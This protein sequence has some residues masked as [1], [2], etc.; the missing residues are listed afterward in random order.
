MPRHSSG[1]RIDDRACRSDVALELNGAGVED[2]VCEH[3][4]GPRG[5]RDGGAEA[6][7]HAAG[8]DGL[9]LAA[10]LLQLELGVGGEGFVGVQETRLSMGATGWAQN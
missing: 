7:D 2:A 5:E 9:A 4:I 1:G 10:A 8:E 6:E 3:I